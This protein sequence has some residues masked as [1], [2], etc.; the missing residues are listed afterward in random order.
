MNDRFVPMWGR[1][2]NS[3]V[4]EFVIV[5][6]FEFGEGSADHDDRPKSGQKS[7]H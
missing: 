4:R 3:P 7:G 5:V 6:G 1:G 2:A